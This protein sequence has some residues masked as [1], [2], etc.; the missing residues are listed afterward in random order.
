MSRTALDWLDQWCQVLRAWL[1]NSPDLSPVEMCQA[2]MK[3]GTTFAHSPLDELK[4]EMEKAWAGIHVDMIDPVSRPFKERLVMCRDIGWRSTS[5]DLWMLS[6]RRC[7]GRIRMATQ[8]TRSPVNR[9]RRSENKLTQP[10][11]GLELERNHGIVQG[12]NDNGSPVS[13]AC[14]FEKARVRETHPIRDFHNR[15]QQCEVK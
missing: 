12:P 1:A 10:T 9:R 15:R 11:P 5:S 3:M 4:V 7:E 6:D 2:I 13:L 8:R 14:L